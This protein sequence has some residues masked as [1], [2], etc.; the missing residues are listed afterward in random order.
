[1]TSRLSPADVVAVD[2]HVHLNDQLTAS[3]APRSS[4][5]MSTYFGQGKALVEIDELADA[6]RQRKMMAVLVNTSNYTTTGIEPVP[7]DHMAQAVADHGDV[8]LSLGAIDPWMGQAAVREV[9]RC[10]D[11]GLHGIGELNPGRQGF[12]PDDRRFFPIWEAIEEAGFPVM[13]HGGMMGAGAGTPGGSGLSLKYCRPIP[14]IDDVAASFPGL[15]ILM[16]HPAWPWQDESLAIALHK[17]N[18]AIDLSGWAPKYFP[19]SLVA[20]ANSR[21]KDQVI[22]GSDWPVIDVERWLREFEELPIK[23]EVRPKILLENAV[24][25]F[26]IDRLQPTA[27]E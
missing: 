10:A 15:R 19:P 4:S 1:M 18:V 25:F 24:R 2:A 22:F 17:S 13:F 20:Y 16:A 27:V 6:Y 11:M 5:G 26:Q 14:H 8:F 9:Q 23:D 3:R 7:N 12:Y 21:L